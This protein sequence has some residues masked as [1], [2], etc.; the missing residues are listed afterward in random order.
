M[1]R[2]LWTVMC[3]GVVA[4]IGGWAMANDVAAPWGTIH[5]NISATAASDDPA[6]QWTLPSGVVKDWELDVKALG[7][8]SPM[9]RG[10]ISFDEAGNL[11]WRTLAPDPKV[12]S[13]APDGTPR[14]EAT[15]DGSTVFNLFTADMTTPVVGDGGETGLV[16]AIGSE[17]A[18]PDAHGIAAAFSKATGIVDWA[19]DLD[20]SAPSN[21]AE[22]GTKLTPALYDGRLYVVGVP[23]A[24]G[25]TSVY[26][27]DAATGALLG[28]SVVTGVEVQ[29]GGALTLVPEPDGVSGV[30][31]LYFNGAKAGAEGVREVYAIAVNTS[32]DTA[33]LGWRAHGGF[34]APVD[35]GQGQGHSHVIYS[36]M[37]GLLYTA[38]WNDYGFTFYSYDPSLTGGGLVGENTNTINNGHGYYD[39]AA[40]D[41]N[42]DIIA[43]GFEGNFVRYM[44]DGSGTTTD[45][46]Y[47][48]ETWYGEPR[49]Y[50]GIYKDASDH[51]IMLTATNS[52]GE[53][54]TAR[55]IAI[56]L[57]TSH[58]NDCLDLDD[59][60]VYIDNLRIVQDGS[61]VVSDGF[62]GYT[63]AGLPDQ[64][65]AGTGSGTLTWINDTG[66]GDSG[67]GEPQIVDDPTGGGM[68]QVLAVDATGGCGGWQGIFGELGTSLT[69]G[70]VTMSWEQ[71]RGDLTDN[72]WVA[73]HLD[74]AKWWALHWD[75][76][77]EAYARQFAFG[78][79]LTA[80][81]WQTVTYRFDLTNFEVTVTVDG[82]TSDVE[83]LDPFAGE[84]EL[85]GWDYEVEGTLTGTA[86]P[87]QADILFA[88]D[89]GIVADNT[90]TTPGGP[91]LGP[92]PP[93]GSRDGSDQHIYYFEYPEPHKLIALRGDNIPPTITAW[94]SSAQ[95]GGPQPIY[96]N[97]F[98][99]LDGVTTRPPVGAPYLY[100]G[101]AVG[102][103]PIGST[104]YM[105]MDVDFGVEWP[106][107]D[108]TVT[109][110]WLDTSLL[111]EAIAPGVPPESG[112]IGFWVRLYSGTEGA[113]GWEFAGY[114]SY[115]FD[116]PTDGEWHDWTRPVDS[117]DEPF[118]DPSLGEHI[119]QAR[120]DAVYWDAAQSPNRFGVSRLAILAP[121]FRGDIPL[122]VGVVDDAVG[123]ECRDAAQTELRIT[124]DEGIEIPEM[125]VVV[126]EGDATGTHAPSDAI[127][128]GAVLTLVF[129]PPL[130]DDY[131]TA[132][133]SDQITDYAGN[134]LAG[135]RTVQFAV[136]RGD[137]QG[138]FDVDL[139]DWYRYQQ[140]LGPVSDECFR[141]DI[142]T[143]GSI[144]VLD[145]VIFAPLMTGP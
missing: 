18:E 96:Q 91:V 24:N 28:A 29:A 138:D 4:S 145:H 48:T 103:V 40:L 25:D 6:L 106:G 127:V 114:Q 36:E 11:Y 1:N 76:T 113:E 41:F 67:L 117:A 52:A 45:G 134:P 16:Y 99:T 81:Q 59:S 137:Y 107:L 31:G 79:P 22:Q 62:E 116:V 139:G 60:P 57:T 42:G 111:W 133:L 46:W 131:Y 119:Y 136:L 84:D 17:S 123:V 21:F 44:D 97:A 66:G 32:T 54:N 144:D 140:C 63:L 23:A 108:I 35:W 82:V 33:T 125:D 5:G 30:H 38:T 14:W 121:P 86:Q 3:V 65:Y 8:D 64:A 15:T 128:D 110:A 69:S 120:I 9:A 105:L 89:T 95:H 93:A 101:G 7:W 73:E 71:Y 78:V 70:V 94:D 19:V 55:V 53:D 98:D 72:C 12:V 26:Q 88:Y 122:P 90:F 77:G 43:G 85:R 142:D 61:T 141:T 130:P 132:T 37:T 129:D 10:G 2:K 47:A 118:E 115:Y 75:A 124:F 74:F 34:V 20:D 92:L 87:Q 112:S 68:G 104:G 27:I 49:V 143:D 109:G 56:D 83:F 126:V 39:V 100:D 13:V 80:G 135:D 51:S 58:L 102:D 50:G